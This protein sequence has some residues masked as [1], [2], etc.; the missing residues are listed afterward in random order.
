MQ[1]MSKQKLKMRCAILN[2]SR[3]HGAE[4]EGADSVRVTGCGV[5]ANTY[6]SK[7]T[8]L[9]KEIHQRRGCMHSLRI[10]FIQVIS[11]ARAI[12]ISLPCFS[13]AWKRRNPL[14]ACQADLDYMWQEESPHYCCVARGKGPGVCLHSGPRCRNKAA[15]SAQRQEIVP[16]SLTLQRPCASSPS[17]SPFPLLWCSLAIYARRCL[18]VSGKPIKS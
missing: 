17:S 7:H 4:L 5:I 3:G 14:S 11:F 10:T 8:S 6:A 1:Q 18:H 9:S 12:F 13:S 2:T 15:L 16:F